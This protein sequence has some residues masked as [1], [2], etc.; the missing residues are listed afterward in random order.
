MWKANEINLSIT[1]SK[2]CHQLLVAFGTYK[3]ISLS[4][5][6]V[7]KTSNNVFARLNNNCSFMTILLQLVILCKRCNAIAKCFSGFKV[8]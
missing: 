8:L 2:N 6:F 3:F 7:L 4:L 5:R 1:N